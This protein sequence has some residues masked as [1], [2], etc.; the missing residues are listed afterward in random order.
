MAYKI[1]I[2]PLAKECLRWIRKYDASLIL[3]DI[4]VIL[5][6][7]PLT[8]LLLI[9]P[10]EIFRSIHAGKDRFRVFYNVSGKTVYVAFIEKRK[11]GK[12]DDAYKKAEINLRR[13]KDEVNHERN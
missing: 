12:Q 6:R 1:I 4:E 3:S 13:M 2:L 10:L 8:R 5:T 7:E 9:P 11:A